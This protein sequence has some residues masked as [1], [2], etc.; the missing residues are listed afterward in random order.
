MEWLNPYI[1]TSMVM[2]FFFSGI[3]IAF[4]S[5]NRLQVELQLKKGRWSQRIIAHFMKNPSQFIGT[6]L[7]GNT[8]S[9]VIFG[10]N[11]TELLNPILIEYLP[12]FLENELALLFIQTFISTMIILVFAEFLPK[13]LFMIN[14]NT[15]LLTF[16]IPFAILHVILTPL[17]FMIVNLSEFVLVKIFR[18]KYSKKLPVFGLTDL[19]HFLRNMQK[20][21]HENVE[22]S[23]DKKIFNNALGF[24]EIRVRDCMLPRTE[25]T[26]IDVNSSISLL[27]KTFIDSGHSKILIYKDSI[28]SII[29]YCHSS[30]LFTNPKTIED[31][32][33]PIDFVTET[34][35]VNGL[36][37]KFLN[38]RKSIATV[39]DEFGGTSGLVTMEDIIEEIFGDIVDEYDKTEHLEQQLTPNSYLLS[40]RLEIEYLN[41]KYNWNLPLGDY[42]TLNGLIL[43]LTGDFPDIG[44]VIKIEDLTVTIQSTK[45]NGINT[46]KIEEKYTK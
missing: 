2:S 31:I 45:G 21:S 9:L 4:L 36:M 41:E 12:K 10:F 13:S 43:S 8:L 5:A 33:T 37:V 39:V 40:A 42:E 35:M 19:N 27:R 26:A 24:K 34:T 44:E 32:L 25:I 18:I 46:V 3:E 7:M 14:P 30:A 16:A 20:V 28:D 23:L 17:T 15:V 22:V 11:I 29:G 38:D 1:I 6:A